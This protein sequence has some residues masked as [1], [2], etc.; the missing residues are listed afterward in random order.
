MLMVFS[1]KALDY[2]KENFSVRN[3][4]ISKMGNEKKKL[5]LYC[6]NNLVMPIFIGYDAG[7]I[8]RGERL[9]EYFYRK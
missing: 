5:G 4:F 8:R 1:S 3:F 6:V 2:K 9:G 7:G